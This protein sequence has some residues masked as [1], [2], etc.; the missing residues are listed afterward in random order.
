M[1]DTLKME[2][3]LNRSMSKYSSYIT[4]FSKPERVSRKLI[5]DSKRQWKGMVTSL[6]PKY[7]DLYLQDEIGDYLRKDLEDTTNLDRVVGAI[8]A[9]RTTIKAMGK[10]SHTE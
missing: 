8:G 6:G 5:M 9:L 2:D 1:D 7:Y 4:A 3:T 10:S